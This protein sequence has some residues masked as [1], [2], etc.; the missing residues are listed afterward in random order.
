MNL[1]IRKDIGFH[2]SIVAFYKSQHGA[3]HDSSS[4]LPYP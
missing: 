3:H 2:H 1:I 4:M